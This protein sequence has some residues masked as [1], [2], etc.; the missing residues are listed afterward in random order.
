MVP[1]QIQIPSEDHARYIKKVLGKY[2][3]IYK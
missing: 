1:V 3:N 2:I